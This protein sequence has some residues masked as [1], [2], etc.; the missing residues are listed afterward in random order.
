MFSGCCR[1]KVGTW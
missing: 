1:G